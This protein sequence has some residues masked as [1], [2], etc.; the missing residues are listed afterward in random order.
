M[1]G[2][3]TVQVCD[4]TKTPIASTAC[5]IKN[6]EQE[7]LYSTVDVKVKIVWKSNA[8]PSLSLGEG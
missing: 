5:Y 3:L 2:R 1:N 6:Q 4:A 8:A 7:Q